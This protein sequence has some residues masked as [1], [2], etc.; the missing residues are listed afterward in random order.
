MGKRIVAVLAIGLGGYL[1]YQLWRDVYRNAEIR[2]MFLLNVAASAALVVALLVPLRPG[3]LS[4]LVVLGGIALAGGSLLAFALSRG[5]GLPT[6]HG[7]WKEMGLQ[8][9]GEM[10][11][12]IKT[13]LVVLITEG[14]ALLACLGILT[15]REQKESI[16]AA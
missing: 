14:I 9:D 16:A 7:I 5:P 1:H 12:G 10:F 8:P 13:A 15:A 2:E 6:P 4:K 11:L 3:L